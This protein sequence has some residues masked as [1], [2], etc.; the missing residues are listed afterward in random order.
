MG[1]GCDYDRYWQCHSCPHRST[2]YREN[3]EH[4]SRC[5]RANRVAID[6]FLKN[7]AT[8]AAME[9]AYLKGVEDVKKDQQK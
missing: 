9:A 2:S 6:R 8:Y 1:Q 7:V 3:D 5:F 4:I